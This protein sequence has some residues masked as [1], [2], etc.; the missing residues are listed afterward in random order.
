M[1]SSSCTTALPYANGPIHLGHAQNK[2]SKDII[3][4]YWSMRGYQTPYVPGW[5][6]H[7][8]P[9]EHKVEESS[10]TEKFNQLPTVKIREICRKLAV[11]QVDTQ[12]QGFKRLGVLGEWDN[13][14]LTY[15]HDYDAGT[16]RSSKSCPRQGRDLPRPQARPLVLP[17]PHGARRGGDR[18]RR[19]GLARHLRALRADDGA[20]G[21]RGLGRQ[22]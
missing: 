16:S 5:D 10:G 20:R 3:N 8:Q 14:Y 6:C 21:P 4:R 2:I 17:L 11:E 9:I 7:G 13:P 12:R 18:V 1:T 19:R 22:A 15:T